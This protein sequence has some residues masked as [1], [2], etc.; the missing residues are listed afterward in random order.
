MRDLVTGLRYVGKG[1]RWVFQ[2]G[3]W[4]GFGLLPA[5]VTLVLNG[6]L[7]VALALWG[8]DL[9]TWATPFAD[10][11]SSPW[12]GLLRGVFVFL[13]FAAA[14]AFGVL[15]FTAV[16]LMVGEPFYERLSEAVEES[17]GYCPAG[18]DRPWYTELW[19]GIADSVYVLLRAVGFG[20]LFF[21]LGFVPAVGQSVVPAVGFLVSGF[22][23]T[24]ELASVAMQRRDIPVRERM[25]LLRRRKALAVGFGTPYVLAFLVPLVAVV[26]MPGAVAGAALLVRDLTGAEDGPGEA[27][28]PRQA[29]DGTPQPYGAPPAAPGPYAPAPGPYPQAHPAANPY[30]T[31]QQKQAPVPPAR[32]QAPQQWPQPPQ[33]QPYGQQPYGQ[34]DPRS[35]YPPPQ[36]PQGPPAGR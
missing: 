17:E 3:R 34:P 7:L 33:A 22:F 23:L 24:L 36:P 25:A 30:A 13:L 11:W 27:A 16:T 26:L 21:V 9:V 35:A 18:P 32:P 2:H 8:T 29:A 28:G 5:L 10:D 20:L 31:P 19:R 1:Q 6:L 12:A 14:L 4:W 15:A